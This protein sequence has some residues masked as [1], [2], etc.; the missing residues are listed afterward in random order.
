[1][2]RRYHDLTLLLV[3]AMLSFPLL[4]IGQQDHK[5]RNTEQGRRV[6]DPEQRNHDNR[7][8]PDDGRVYDRSRHDYHPWTDNEDRAYRKYLA[9][10]HKAYREFERNSRSEQARYWS[11]RHAHPDHKDRTEHNR[12]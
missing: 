6:D 12:Q 5:S 1:M 2:N 7:N 9:E 4:A 3:M 11:W 8:T 10:K